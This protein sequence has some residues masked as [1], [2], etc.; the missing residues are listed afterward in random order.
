MLVVLLVSY[1][2]DGL[3]RGD[4]RKRRMR[5]IITPV[6]VMEMQR[7]ENFGIACTQRWITADY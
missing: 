4:W 1:G 2:D 5:R 3:K 7:M 6:I